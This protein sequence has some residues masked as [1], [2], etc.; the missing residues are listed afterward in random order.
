MLALTK[1]DPG[2]ERIGRTVAG[3]YRI[4][5]GIGL[6]ACAAVYRAVC[7]RTGRHVALKMLLHP[8][9]TDSLVAARFRNEASAL[10]ALRHGGVADLLD[11]G[12]AEDGCPFIVMELLVGQSLRDFIAECGPMSPREALIVAVRL[13]GILDHLHQRG[14]VHRD[15]KPG[16]VFLEAVEGGHV[17]V[18]LLDLGFAYRM[19]REGGVTERGLG[20][21]QHFRVHTG[22][23]IVLG[24]PQ[25]MSPEQCTAGVPVDARS[26]VYSLGILLY[27][28]LRG[29][30]PFTADSPMRVMNAHLFLRPP[31]LA[32]PRHGSAGIAVSPAL[33][34][35]VMRA[36]EKDPSS[37]FGSMSEF[38]S[39]LLDAAHGNPRSSHAGDTARVPSAS[40]SQKR[41]SGVFASLAQKAPR[42]LGR[43]AKGEGSHEGKT[44][45]LLVS[46][47][48]RAM[49]RIGIF[50]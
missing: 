33:E 11:E 39:A 34:A 9:G 47:I 10:D 12:T 19:A 30:P 5:E 29:S 32:F 50:G 23:G 4:E 13:A 38:A 41:E 6:G 48:Q 37:R 43:W 3:K 17:S 18:R 15:V 49:N 42:L 45:R 40:P 21:P 24:T 7:L 22:P 1:T 31:E 28:L 27:E 26:D 8:P 14:F 16:N 25:Y 35:V 2:A 20:V 46:E 44:P 36:L